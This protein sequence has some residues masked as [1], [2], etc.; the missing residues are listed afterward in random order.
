MPFSL[1]PTLSAGWWEDC[2]SQM[3]DI[4]LYLTKNSV[5]HQKLALPQEKREFI[6]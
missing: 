4:D 3:G 1:P 5:S 6:H 2:T